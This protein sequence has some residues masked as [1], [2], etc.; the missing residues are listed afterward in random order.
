MSGTRPVRGVAWIYS[1][2][3]LQRSPSLLPGPRATSMGLCCM[4]PELLSYVAW[5][6]S[7]MQPLQ[8]CA[9]CDGYST[10]LGHEL[11][12]A[13]HTANESIHLVSSLKCWDFIRPCMLS[14][15]HFE[16]HGQHQGQDD[17]TLGQWLRSSI[18]LT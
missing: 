18:P 7:S 15:G 17:R 5:P 12:Q 16:I 9:A 2:V 1:L 4:F 13:L 3:L 6:Q 11:E 8:G 14:V 10:T